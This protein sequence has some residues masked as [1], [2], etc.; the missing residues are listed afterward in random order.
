MGNYLETIY[1][2]DEQDEDAYP[3][4]LCDHLINMFSLHPSLKPNILDV[5]CGK[6]NQLVGFARRGF[7]CTGI[8]RRAE[9]LTE[10]DKYASRIKLKVC[11]LEQE[12]PLLGGSFD[13][14]FSKSVIEHIQNADHVLK[15]IYRVLKP[16]GIAILMT[17]DWNSQH[18]VF[19]DDYT[20]VKP[21][22][23]K[24]LQDAMLMHDFK[25]V[26]CTLFRQLPILWKHPW[27]KPICDLVSIV[28]HSWKWKDE[29]E[30]Y[31]REFIRFSKEKMLLATGIK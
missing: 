1:F 10:P 31:F 9:C 24:G 18:E 15:E 16:G 22:T 8:D 20:H 11:D 21:W 28:P 14:V 3:Q 17:P 19:W 23:R 29:E 6:G 27:L 7:M 5:G 26:E 2:R 30:K 25:S 4:K 12:I 13:I